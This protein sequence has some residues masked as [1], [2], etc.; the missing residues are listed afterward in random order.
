MAAEASAIASAL[1]TKDA[2]VKYIVVVLYLSK[3]W[4]IRCYA[5]H[6]SRKGRLERY[7]RKLK[8][9]VKRMNTEIQVK[10]IMSVIWT[11]SKRYNKG[12]QTYV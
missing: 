11:K 4:N 2:L 8:E 1:S 7:G 12:Q 6:R 5:D 3:E 10:S 9:S